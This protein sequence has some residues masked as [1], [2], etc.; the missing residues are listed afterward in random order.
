ML[1]LLVS[2]AS[3]SKPTEAFTRS[4]K[5]RRAV[6]GSP[7]RNSVAA[8]SSM[9]LAKAGSRAARSFTV[10]LKSQVSSMSSSPARCLRSRLSGL[11]FC[12]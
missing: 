5:M 4:R 8:S 6:W 2:T 7:L 11:V 9:A 12:Q 10:S 3:V 1:G